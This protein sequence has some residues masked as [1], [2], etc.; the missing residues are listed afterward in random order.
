[1][2]SAPATAEYF[3]LTNGL[4]G[5]PQTTHLARAGPSDPTSVERSIWSRD[6]VPIVAFYRINGGGHVVPQPA[7][8]WPRILGRTL[9]DLNAPKASWDFFASGSQ[10]R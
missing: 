9:P 3:V 8:R 4:T 5:S 10:V 1:M 6:G 2:R 7:Y